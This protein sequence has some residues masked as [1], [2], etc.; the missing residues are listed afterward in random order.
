MKTKILLLIF[1]QL[2]FVRSFLF[3]QTQ[4]VRSY[5]GVSHDIGTSVLQ[6]SDGGYIVAGNTLSFGAG[7]WDVFVIKTN[8]QGDTFWAKTYGTPM[9]DGLSIWG[10]GGPSIIAASDGGHLI[11][12]TNAGG[13]NA[14]QDVYLIKIDTSGNIQW[15]RNYG[16]YG[17][18]FAYSAIQKSNG[19]YLFVGFLDS[20]FIVGNR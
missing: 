14:N 16:G 17:N 6:I 1:I 2:F 18:D 5:G 7:S 12:T 13:I 19:N 10:K 3:S 8:D 9:T 20:L 11:A 15:S 4:F